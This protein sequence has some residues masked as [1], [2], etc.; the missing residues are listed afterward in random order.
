MSGEASPPVVPRAWK[1]IEGAGKN[2]LIGEVGGAVWDEAAGLFWVSGSFADD[3]E[4]APRGRGAERATP[5]C[6]I[7]GY[8]PV[9][10]PDGSTELR[11]RVLLVLQDNEAGQGRIR[12]GEGVTLSLQGGGKIGLDPGKSGDG[13]A[14]EK[15]FVL[16]LDLVSGA[17]G[18]Y[19]GGRIY[20]RFEHQPEPLADQWYRD[21]RRVFLKQFNV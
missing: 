9:D 10:A 19:V 20:V 12:N 7:A 11:R 8:S 17:P 18:G 6:V 3:Y 14:L 21:I 13:K 4:L 1:A 5:V 2:S 16:D 15:L